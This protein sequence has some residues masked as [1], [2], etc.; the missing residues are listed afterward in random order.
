MISGI[1]LLV[2]ALALWAPNAGAQ[3]DPAGVPRHLA[4][5]RELVE[6]TR[7]EN[8]QYKLGSQFISF[9][10]DP[11]GKYQVRADCSGFLLAIFA[12]AKY[13]TRSMMGFLPGTSRKGKRPA[14]EDFVHSIEMEQGFRRIRDIRD[15][16]PGDLLA[17]AML[18]LADQK[19]TGTTGHVFLIDSVPKA[20]PPRIPV[21]AGTTQF[22]I[23]I[24]DSNEEHVGTDDTRLADPA[25][26]VKG[27]GRGTIRIYA[28]ADGALVGWARTF[29]HVKRFFSY[30][31]R[32]PSDTKLRK[33][34][35]GRP[36]AGD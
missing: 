36:V 23:A 34:A 16:R 8:N 33:A 9:P 28:D 4:I 7:P 14:S 3:A 19:Q 6:H 25:N 22:E 5:A 35:I 24:I 11:A 27:L 32:F 29:R 31:S 17:H 12:R 26:K 30:D 18:D 10:G 13:P 21:V 1:R 15:I 2:A 20:I